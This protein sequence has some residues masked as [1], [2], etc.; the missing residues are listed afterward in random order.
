ML[1]EFLENSMDRAVR[2]VHHDDQ[3]LFAEVV[4]SLERLLDK[5]LTVDERQFV[6]VL[7]A[8]LDQ[9]PLSVSSLQ[10]IA[11]LRVWTIT[12]MTRKGW[13]TGGHHA[14]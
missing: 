10:E 13:I 1:P 8:E 6:T 2:S 4:N 5:A 14:V 11:N 12:A 7:V 3:K 9:I